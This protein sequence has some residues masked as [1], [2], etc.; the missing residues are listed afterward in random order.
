MQ[1]N[2]V[3]PEELARMRGA[4]APVVEKYSKEVGEDLVKELNAEIAKVRG[5]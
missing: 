2:D 4:V 5:S 1:V 3:S